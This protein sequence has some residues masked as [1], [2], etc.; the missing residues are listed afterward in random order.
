VRR[1]SP[2]LGSLLW[3]VVGMIVAGLLF[4]AHTLVSHDKSDE[5]DNHAV[6]DAGK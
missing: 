1:D 3:V 2:V 4:L 6:Y 5:V